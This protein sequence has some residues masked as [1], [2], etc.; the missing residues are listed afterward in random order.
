MNVL[1]L[2]N[3]KQRALA[4]IGAAALSLTMVVPALA[5]TVAQTVD[6]RTDRGPLHLERPALGDVELEAEGGRV[7]RPILPPV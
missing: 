5:S 1:T 6:D 4:L 7:H 3:T 2:K